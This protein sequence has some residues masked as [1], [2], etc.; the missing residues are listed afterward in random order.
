MSLKECLKNNQ[1][2]ERFVRNTK[3]ET[4]LSNTIKHI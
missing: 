2:K 3:Y 1:K 4:F